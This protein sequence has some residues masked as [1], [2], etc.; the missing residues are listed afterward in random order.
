MRTHI[1]CINLT[2]LHQIDGMP[3]FDDAPLLVATNAR[4]KKTISKLPTPSHPLPPPLPIQTSKL[5]SQLDSS[6]KIGLSAAQAK[7]SPEGVNAGASLQPEISLE[8]GK[9]KTV[10]VRT[11]RVEACS[12]LA[13]RIIVR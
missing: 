5:E 8:K 4:D 2:P 12:S 3:F 1:L 10:D 7:A 9:S 6:M 11:R 13:R